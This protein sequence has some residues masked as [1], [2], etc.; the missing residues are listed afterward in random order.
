V[1]LRW[2]LVAATIGFA[3]PAFAQ[4]EEIVLPKEN[5]SFNGPFGTF[6]RASVQRGYQVY[7][8]VCSN[9][10]SMRLLSYRDL[11]GIGLNE[12]QIKA[13]AASVTVGGSTDDSGQPI[14]RP[15]LPAD[16]FKSPFANEKARR[17]WRRAAAG[18]VV[19]HQGP[20][21]WPGLHSCIAERLS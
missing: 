19:D 12:E 6:D 4:H 9:C 10:H 20:R 3:T 17:K 5:W 16:R 11:S 21:E 14:D 1:M 2:V 15:G 18:P 13:I 8:E 7:K